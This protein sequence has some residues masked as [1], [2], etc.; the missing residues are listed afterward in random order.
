MPIKYFIC[1]SAAVS[2]GAMQRYQSATICGEKVV[3]QCFMAEKGGTR[4]EIPD[5]AAIYWGIVH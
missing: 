2:A 1:R 3:Q 4:F 5:R